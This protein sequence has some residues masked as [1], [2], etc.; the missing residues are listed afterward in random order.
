M[1]RGTIVKIISAAG[2]EQ[3]LGKLLSIHAPSMHEH[4]LKSYLYV[5]EARSLN[6]EL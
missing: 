6:T 2:T 1:F 5:A 3:V 4:S